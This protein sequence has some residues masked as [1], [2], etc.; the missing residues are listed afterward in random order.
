MN[1]FNL[2]KLDNGAYV[3]N[4][5]TRTP[6]QHMIK[7][8]ALTED[9]KVVVGGSDHGVVYVFD[10]ETGSTLN[11]LHHADGGLVQTVTVSILLHPSEPKP[12]HST[13]P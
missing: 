6:K 3:R 4:F 8:V 9:S 13:G 11:T 1:G 10:R 12:K 2:H 7:Q 5:P